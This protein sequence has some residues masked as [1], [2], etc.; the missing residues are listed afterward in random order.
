M[1]WSLE[2]VS[3]AP[4][5]VTL[6]FFDGVHRGHQQLVDHA[7][8]HGAADS[9]RTVA[10]TFDRH[11]TQV[12]RPGSEPP[13]LMTL[14]RR[15]HT[16]QEVGADLVLVI[17]FTVELSELSPSGFVD[18]VLC[19]ALNAQVVVVGEN[20][21]FGHLAAGDARALSRIGDDRGFDVDIVELLTCD[22]E[23]L[24]STQIRRHL[25]EGDVEWAAAALGRPH[26]ID[27][28]VVQGEGRG[29]SIGIPTANVAVAPHTQLPANGVYAGLVELVP[30]VPGRA[31]RRIPAVTNVGVR[32][33]FGEEALT[34]ETHL[35]DFEGDLYGARLGV[36]FAHRLR[37]ERRFADPE[38]LVAQ[39]R[40]DMAKGRDLLGLPRHP[41]A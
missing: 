27:G 14:E 1:A 4:S 19:S 22:G 25:A 11:P 8:R 40:A 37:K 39:I 33:T 29:R 17:P 18:E 35:L 5:A 24:S 26:V 20:F 15:V 9:L 31:V 3:P 21:R 41:P 34:V 10:A 23:P 7:A 32:P 38:Q 2:D 30:E 16:L 6:G 28:V 13:L 12:L 36:E